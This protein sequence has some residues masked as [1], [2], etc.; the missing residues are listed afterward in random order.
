[1]IIFLPFSYALLVPSHLAVS[2]DQ[3]AILIA[4]NPRREQ[5]DFFLVESTDQL[6]VDLFPLYRVIFFSVIVVFRSGLVT[7]LMTLSAAHHIWL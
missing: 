1:M 6:L 5:V 2:F 4:V 7:S 3:I